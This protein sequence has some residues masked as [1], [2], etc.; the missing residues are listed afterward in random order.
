MELKKHPR[1]DLNRKRGLFM[2]IGLIISLSLT[3]SAFE[4]KFYDDLQTIDLGS[5]E[6][7]F[8]EEIYLPT[9][10]E[11]PPPPPVVQNPVIIEVDDK[12]EIPDVELVINIEDQLT[13]PVELVLPPVDAPVPAHI[14]EEVVDTFLIVEQMPEPQGGMK[15]FFDY[16]GKNIKYPKQARRVGIEGQVVVQFVIDKDGNLRN[17]K[18][19]KGIGGGCDEEAL[20]VMRSAPAWKPGKQRGRPVMVRMS[21]PIVFQLD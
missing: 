2:N 20:R 18:I 12:V 8:V 14:K 11:V 17:F 15:A 10:P 19:I 21:L 9:I 6:S 5:L 16:I 7:E 4:W 13:E 3:I 1:V